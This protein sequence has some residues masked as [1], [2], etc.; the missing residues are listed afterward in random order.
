MRGR[1]RAGPGAWGLGAWLAPLIVSAA[2]S[3]GAWAWLGWPVD[4]PPAPEP[5]L[6]CAS[7]TPFRGD[8]T[9]FD[10]TLMIPKAQIEE[11]LKQLQPTTDCVRTYAVDQGLDQV[12]P[13]AAALNMQ[14]LL[15]IWIG[16][17]PQAN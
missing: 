2:L 12:V 4:L 15:G 10:P 1:G 16:R 5:K 6:H 9:P 11:D 8:Q 7:Y 3:A 17:D 14:V 13:I